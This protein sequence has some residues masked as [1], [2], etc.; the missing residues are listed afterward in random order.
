MI[1]STDM[2][3]PVTRGELQDTLGLFQ[4]ELRTEHQ[5][6]LQAAIAP[7]ATKADLAGLATKAEIAPLATKAEIAP[8]ATKAELEVWGG[9][10]LDR[11]R[12]GD[13]RLDELEQR[14]NA[15][16]DHFEQRLSDRLQQTEHRLMQEL[17]RH[18]SALLESMQTQIKA[19]FEPHADLPERVRRLEEAAESRPPARPTRRRKN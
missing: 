9:A 2:S 11:I 6:E 13:R 15:R 10:L 14:V 3:T 19:C 5:H 8:L 7:L 18:A 17:A 16:F 1:D 12:Q 4:Q